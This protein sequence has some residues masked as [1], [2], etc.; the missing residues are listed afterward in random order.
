VNLFF[1]GA[2][3]LVYIRTMMSTQRRRRR[4][5]RRYIIAHC[6]A[7]LSLPWLVRDKK[8]AVGPCLIAPLFISSITVVVPNPT[9]SKSVCAIRRGRTLPRVGSAEP[10]PRQR[11]HQLHHE[12]DEKTKHQQPCTKQDDDVLLRNQHH[13]TARMPPKA[14][15]LSSLLPLQTTSTLWSRRGIA[16]NKRGFF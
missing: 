7:A 14:K 8:S 9:V 4:R 11:R 6:Q 10:V 2:V 5:R 3:A 13:G 1:V 15:P 16:L 12:N